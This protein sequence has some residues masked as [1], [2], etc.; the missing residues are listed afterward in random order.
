MK[1]LIHILAEEIEFYGL[2]VLAIKCESRD[3]NIPF[4]TGDIEFVCVCVFICGWMMSTH[5]GESHLLC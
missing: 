3:L 2:I 4:I 1:G 5:T